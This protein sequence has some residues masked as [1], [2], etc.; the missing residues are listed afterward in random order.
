VL[1]V[2]PGIIGTIQAMEAIKI[3]LGAGQPLIGRLLVFDALG[4]R[5]REFALQR[6]PSCPICG[7]NRTI[8]ELVDYDELCGVTPH[9]PA[10]EPGD[11]TV[12]D[13]HQW[14]SQPDAPQLVDV[15]EPQEHQ[16]CRIAQARLIPLGE[17]PRR[18]QEIDASRP[19]VVHCKSGQRSAKAVSL[20]R[21]A[22]FDARN[23]RG[24]ILAWIDEVDRTQ[25]KY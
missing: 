22:G 8:H 21:G 13:L 5:F 7:D 4:M 1:G 11:V 12:Q 3:I 19:V 14:L 18:L 2:L 20:L 25:P 10:R 23:L 9:D 6:D 15:R 24:G 17:L 16:I